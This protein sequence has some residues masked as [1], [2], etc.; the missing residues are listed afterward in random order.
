[1]HI[2]DPLLTPTARLCLY[3]LQATPNQT[4]IQLMD[5]TGTRNKSTLFDALRILQAAKMVI[6]SADRPATYFLT[7]TEVVSCE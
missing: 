7:Q 2:S 5:T 3:S 6:K 4:F 1:M